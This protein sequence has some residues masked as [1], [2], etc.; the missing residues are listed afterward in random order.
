[1]Y[2]LLYAVVLAIF[3]FR[4]LRLTP[5]RYPNVNE[6]ELFNFRWHLL[7]RYRQYAVFFI[8]VFIL[9]FIN[10]ALGSYAHSH[11]GQKLYM[12][13]FYGLTIFILAVNLVILTIIIRN[14]IAHYQY[15]RSLGI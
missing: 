7:K 5:E 12:N 3:W 2:L 11:L 9:A 13:L 1:M 14:A 4:A 15:R 8:L 6:Q 10:G